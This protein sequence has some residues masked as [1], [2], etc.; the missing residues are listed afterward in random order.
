M[1]V[2]GFLE[3]NWTCLKGNMTLKI[4]KINNWLQ[5]YDLACIAFWQ[6]QRRLVLHFGNSREGRKHSEILKIDILLM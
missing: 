6:Q 2:F 4:A 1:K 3:P 5:D